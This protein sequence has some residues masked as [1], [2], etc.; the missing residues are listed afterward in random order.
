MVR[1]TPDGGTDALTHGRTHIHRTKIV[2]AMSP[3]PASGLDKNNSAVIYTEMTCAMK[4]IC[5]FFCLVIF[6]LIK[7]EAHYKSFA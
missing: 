5:D 1:T 6:K 7:F 3:L 2:T 4:D